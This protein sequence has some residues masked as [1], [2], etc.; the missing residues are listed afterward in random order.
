[1]FQ[2]VADEMQDETRGVLFACKFFGDWGLSTLWGALTDV[3]GPASGTV[4][5][6][7]NTVGAAAAFLA[8][9]AMGWL[10][11]VHGWEGLFVSTATM[12]WLAA[13]CWLVIDSKQR[14]WK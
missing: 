1:V 6:V 11:Q 3:G 8:S 13:A 12:C 7:V 14:L 4:F 2:A 10:K 9:A 5:G